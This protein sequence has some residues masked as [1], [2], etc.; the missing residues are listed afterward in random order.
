MSL[1]ILARSSVVAVLLVRVVGAFVSVLGAV[2]LSRGSSP[3]FCRWAA[4]IEVDNKTI[5]TAPRATF[6]RFNMI[7]T[8]L[9]F[10]FRVHQAVPHS[11]YTS[12][13]GAG[14]RCDREIW[15]F[16]GLLQCIPRGF[17]GTIRQIC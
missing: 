5:E 2:C 16:L 1:S 10:A 3:R 13:N 11:L 9:E 12:S 8:L 6:L 7:A 15:F 14:E 17:R 4:A